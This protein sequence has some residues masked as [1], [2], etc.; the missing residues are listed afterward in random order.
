MSAYCVVVC[1]GNRARFFT[2]E[3]AGV[4]G[5]SGPKLVECSDLVNAEAAATGK[6]NWAETKSGRNTAPGGGG[7]HGYDDH[8]EHHEEEFVRRFASDVTTEAG[9][10]VQANKGKHL[11]LVA[12]NRM[13]GYLRNSLEM[14]AIAQVE[15]KEVAKDLIKF[16]A[17]DIHEHLSDAGLLPVRKRASV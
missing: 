3:P 1:N 6:N 16:S 17:Q 2:L 9:R 7:A 10:L 14:P 15:V 8:R 4:P 12:A 13:L 5:E 11:I